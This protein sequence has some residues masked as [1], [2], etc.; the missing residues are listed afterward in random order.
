MRSRP[1]EH[2]GLR[3]Q[4]LAQLAASQYWMEPE[5]RETR[6]TE[7]LAAANEGLDL[8]RRDGDA[9]VLAHVLAAH[10]LATWSPDTLGE[11][12]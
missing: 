8:A 6:T 2:V 10:S 11:A 4:V 1:R 3:G 7:R 12:D 5:E 9:G